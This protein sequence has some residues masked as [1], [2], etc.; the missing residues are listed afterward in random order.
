MIKSQPKTPAVMIERYRES[1]SYDKEN[2]EDHLTLG[3]EK[4]KA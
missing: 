1:N 4:G 2:C 3:A